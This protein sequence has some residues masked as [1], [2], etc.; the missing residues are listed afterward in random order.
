[1]R[2]PAIRVDGAL[3]HR[4]DSL[5]G[6]VLDRERR[7][8]D[9]DPQHEAERQRPGPGAQQPRELR[10]QADRG[11][12]DADQEHGERSDGVVPG[13]RD[14][15]GAVDE[16]R[17]QEPEDEPRRDAAPRDAYARAVPLARSPE[18]DRASGTARAYASRG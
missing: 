15:P 18:G 6:R 13:G 4:R 11:E 17:A 7:D 10:L 12:R 1:M 5:S 9:G 14:D 8:G 2:E 16:R 3:T